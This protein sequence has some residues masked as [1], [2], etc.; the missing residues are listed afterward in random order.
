MQDPTGPCWKY[1]GHIYRTLVDPY[2][3]YQ[4]FLVTKAVLRF[5]VISG[6][7]QAFS[8]LRRDDTADWG[9][10]TP[11]TTVASWGFGP[12][13]EV[14]ITP[15]VQ[16]WCTG[17]LPNHGLIIC[18]GDESFAHN[19]ANAQCVLSNPELVITRTEYK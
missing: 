19:N 10:T 12:P 18:G 13:V 16:A 11:V 9:K 4:G 7:K 15:L 1:I 6:T 3:I 17:Q 8:I 2:G 5:S 14:D